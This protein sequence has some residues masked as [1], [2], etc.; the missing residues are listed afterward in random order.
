[1]P[2]KGRIKRLDPIPGDPDHKM[3]VW[4]DLYAFREVHEI[5]PASMNMGQIRQY[6]RARLQNMGPV[7]GQEITG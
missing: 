5:I 3:L 1:M 2:K 4:E 6:V 7:T